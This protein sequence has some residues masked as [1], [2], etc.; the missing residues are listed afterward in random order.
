MQCPLCGGALE[1]LSCPL[2][3]AE[4]LPDA[5][6]CCRCGG[7]LEREELPPELANRV[8]CPDGACIGILND[9]GECSVCG[10]DYKDVLASEGSR[11]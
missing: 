4:T 10:F 1:M 11:G 9:Q 7:S 8:L 3:G 2:C 6:F 5:P